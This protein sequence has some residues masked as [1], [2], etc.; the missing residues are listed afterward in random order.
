MLF[1]I[2]GCEIA[3]IS[4]LYS[5]IVDINGEGT[6]AVDS[7]MQFIRQ[8]FQEN[9][10]AGNC[11][12]TTPTSPPFNVN[13]TV[14]AHGNSLEWFAQFIN[15]ECAYSADVVGV[16][17]IREELDLA[18]D[19]EDYAVVRRHIGALSRIKTTRLTIDACL[20]NYGVEVVSTAGTGAWCVCSGVFQTNAEWLGILAAVALAAI[21]LQAIMLGLTLWLIRHTKYDK[22]GLDGG[23]SI[24]ACKGVSAWVRCWWWVVCGCGRCSKDSKHAKAVKAKHAKVAKAK[25]AKAVKAKHA[26]EGAA[27]H[28]KHEKE[29]EEEGGAGTQATKR[30][31]KHP[32]NVEISIGSLTA[33]TSDARNASETVVAEALS[34]TKGALLKHKKRHAKKHARDTELEEMGVEP[35]VE[36]GEVEGSSSPDGSKKR[37][38]KVRKPGTVLTVV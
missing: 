25:H 11:A 3:G 16:G 26:K 29:R 14:D 10:Q 8:H 37:E 23:L 5:S 33:A 17:T 32:H 7:T 6:G 34:G 28:A 27:K 36:G 19:T 12:V 15:T 18:L 35:E 38:G 21:C 2:M 31:S 24:A 22:D 30:K 20:E 9:F 1:L 13:C 4:I